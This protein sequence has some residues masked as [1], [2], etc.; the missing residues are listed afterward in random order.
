M[1]NYDFRKIENKWQDR[2]K[3]DQTFR[4]DNSSKKPKYYVLDMFPY[5][6][7]AGLHVG[8]PLGY[9]ASDIVSRFKMNQGF[10]VLHPMGFDAFGLPAEQ[11]AIQTGQHPAITTKNNIERYKDQMNKIGFAYD[12]SREVQ[13]CDPAYY[14]WTQWIFMKLF[15]SWYERDADKARPIDALI[16]ILEKSGSERLNAVCDE[17]TDHLTAEQWNELTWEDQQ[18]YLLKYRMAFLAE[19][20][21]NWCAA[22]GTVLSNDE[23]KDG[24]SERGG[25]PVERKKMMQWC[26]RITAYAERL[27]K[28]LD[29]LDWSEALKEIQ[30][31]WIGRSQGGELDFPIQGKEERIR[32]FTTRPDTIFGVTF[33]TLAPE[34]EWVD[35]LTTPEQRTAVKQYVKEASNRSER[36]RLS[37][38]KRVTGVFTGSYVLHP[39]TQKPLPIWVAD[40]VLAGYGTGAVMAVPAHDT[41]DFAFAKKFNLPILKVIDGGPEDEAY[42]AKEGKAIN[43]DFLNGLEVKEAIARAIER[44]EAQEIGIGKINYRIR[45]A[46]F[47]RQRYWGEPLPVYFKGEIPCLVS[48]KDLP[49]ILPEVDK[50]LP[51]E[52]GEPPL[53]RAKNW[54]YKAEDGK[55]YPLEKSTM[56]GWAGSSWYFFR[57]M[58]AD[59]AQAFCSK[60]AQAYWESVD[61]YIGGAEHATGHLLYARFWT[62]FLYDLGLINT[63]EPFKKLVN[64][65]MIQGRSS[66]AYRITGTNK[67]VSANLKDQYE[68]SPMHVD[69][70]LVKDDV[71]DLEK[72]R[73]W[74]PDLAEADF[75]TEGSK[76]YCGFEVEK[77]SKSRFN[78]VTP[79]DIIEGYG[80]DTLRMYEMFLGP[81]E[82]SK[83]WNTNGIDGVFK[84]LNK[85][86]RLFHNETGE[87]AVVD[88]SASPQELKSIHTAIKKVNEDLQRLAFNTP[89][90]SLMICVNELTALKCRKRN[91]LEILT[92][93][94]SPFAPH[95][96]EELWEC[97]G[98]KGTVARAPFPKHDES[99]LLE[100]TYEYPVSVNGKLRTKM[101]LALDMSPGD[102][103]KAVLDAE[104]VQKWL[105][106]KTPKKV[107]VVPG[108]IVNIVV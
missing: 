15:D 1:S 65:G 92:V 8:H 74:R 99:F 57:Y 104:P 40:Y 34:S 96:A 50:Y 87:W 6:S 42:D 102:I 72:F 90:S 80:A 94:L 83:P 108:K 31:N 53:A 77:M 93:L 55:E 33:M 14:K 70:S 61:L 75:I 43:S 88:D 27:I 12:W 5:P 73:K 7:G 64:Q 21:V 103:E 2:W 26:L 86:W 82:Q 100:S 52:S 59:N 20:S 28:G 62:K 48:E 13:T 44:L 18:K 17:G 91:I 69:V 89:V 10:N 97:L 85:V 41:R 46:I 58:D 32:V 36:D 9:I 39:F 51:T 49:L 54:V 38:V 76:F 35:K 24:Y 47:T 79:D 3:K 19:T 4:A 56:P 25:H 105:D 67:F 81:L 23:V 84:F 37:E 30:R 60:D 66:L 16:T 22:L 45:D 78:V 101:D 63:D 106:G 98:Q 11:Y 95:L 71:L 107:I 29:H 68:T